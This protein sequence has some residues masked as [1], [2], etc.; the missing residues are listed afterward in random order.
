[1]KTFDEHCY[2]DDQMRPCQKTAQARALQID[3]SFVVE[4]REGPMAGDPGDYLMEGVAGELY[5]CAEAVFDKTYAWVDL[6]EQISQARGESGAW[7]SKYK[8][9]HGVLLKELLDEAPDYLRGLD[10]ITAIEEE[11][12]Q[13]AD[14]PDRRAVARAWLKAHQDGAFELDHPLLKYFT[15]EHLPDHLQ[16][17]SRPFCR[18][19]HQI[20]RQDGDE[21]EQRV[22]LRK[23]LEAKDA[24]VRAEVSS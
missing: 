24:A 11:R 12:V 7:V 2:P 20:A 8:K 23:L 14:M 10:N 3:E 19:A 17:V 9:N 16:E 22:A 4:S 1:M 15:Y 6:E 13:W 18:L 5:V 21:T